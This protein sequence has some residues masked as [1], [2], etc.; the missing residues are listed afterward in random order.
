MSQLPKTKPVFK[1]R[2]SSSRVLMYPVLLSEVCFLHEG[3][4][5]RIMNHFISFLLR[6]NWHIIL[7][8][9]V[10]HN[11]SIFLLTACHCHDKILYFLFCTLYPWN[12]SILYLNSLYYLYYLNSLHPHFPL[13]ITSYFSVVSLFLFCYIYPNC[14]LFQIPHVS[15]NIQYLLVYVFVLFK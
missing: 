7:V 8:S 14:L 4:L 2:W 3:P 1:S 12:L 13:I 9:D 5:L 11:D 10:Q 15:E 6:Y